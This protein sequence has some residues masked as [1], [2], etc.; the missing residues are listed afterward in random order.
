MI[1]DPETYDKFDKVILTHTCRQ[2]AE[3]AYGRDLAARIESDETLT[4]MVD[5]KLTL[6]STT[7]REPSD[8]MGRMTD[9]IRD[10]RLRKCRAVRSIRRPTA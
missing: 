7:T 4:E 10:G 1:R 3:L 9:W 6:I 8:A 5:G 2:V